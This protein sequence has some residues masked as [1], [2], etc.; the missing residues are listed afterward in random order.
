MVLSNGLLDGVV[1]NTQVR[2]VPVRAPQLLKLR[3]KLERDLPVRV[4][5]LVHVL[6]LL[7]AEDLL[8]EAGP[9]VGGRPQTGGGDPR[10]EKRSCGAGSKS[11]EDPASDGEAATHDTGTGAQTPAD[12]APKGRVKKY[13]LCNLVFH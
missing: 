2:R 12:P 6:D 9:D 13:L 8:D 4:E 5:G 3:L 11:G 10:D 1:E 7:A